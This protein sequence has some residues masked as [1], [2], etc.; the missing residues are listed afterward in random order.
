MHKTVSAR[1]NLHKSTEISRFNHCA[2]IYCA[3]LRFSGDFVDPLKS[4]IG[5]FLAGGRN[6][7]TAVILNFNLGVGFS[8]KCTNNLT[9]RSDN[10]PYFVRIDLDGGDLGCVL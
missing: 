6:F 10:L 7:D 2:L 8:L 9:T 4:S 1:K 5:I 3:D